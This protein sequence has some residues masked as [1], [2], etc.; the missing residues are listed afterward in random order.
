MTYEEFKRELYRNIL[1]Q[2]EGDKQI[3]LF[4]R[5]SICSD[6]KDLQIIKAL[7]LSCYGVAD[8]VVHEDI[9]CILWGSSANRNI[10]HWK[11]RTLYERYKREGWQSVLPEIIVKLEEVGRNS[12]LFSM[13]NASYEQ[14]C[15]RLIL[16]PLNMQQHRVELENCVYWKF[17]DIAMVLYGLLSDDGAD[18]VSM[19]MRREITGR[20]NISDEKILIHALLN[21]YEKM[22]PRLFHAGE[23]TLNPEPDCGVFMSGE[24]GKRIVIQRNDRWDGIR[25]YRLTTTRQV[26][27]ALAIFYPGVK[28]RLAKMM[29]GDYFVGF[30]SVHEAVIHPVHCKNLVDMKAAIQHINAVFD[31]QD[32]L[33]NRVY[34]YCCKRKHLLEV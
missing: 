26:N 7:N 33:T 29:G 18:Y 9:L 13:E 2:E 16:R 20:W 22:P 4:E 27:G 23:M 21:C 24:K 8:L 34:R 5:R 31:E 28:E 14:C 17:G 25:G 15:D 12:R 3:R 32:M 1:Q 10:I 11:V 6:I 19:K 30:T